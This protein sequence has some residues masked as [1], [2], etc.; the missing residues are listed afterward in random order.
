MLK[1]PVAAVRLTVA[2]MVED[3]LPPEMEEGLKLMVVPL[4]CPDAAS[5]M[6]E[7]VP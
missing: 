6:E 5:A 3:P 7:M 4:P 1:V 2:F